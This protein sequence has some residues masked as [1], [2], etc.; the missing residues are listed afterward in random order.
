MTAW[1][2]RF[3]WPDSG[4]PWSAGRATGRPR[5]TDETRRPQLFHDLI[6]K[7]ILSIIYLMRQLC[8]GIRNGTNRAGRPT[9]HALLVVELPLHRPLGGV[10]RRRQLLRRRG[11]QAFGV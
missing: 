10:G 5:S 4:G 7:S 1:C 2:W 11:A 6:P 9:P 8:L 3:R